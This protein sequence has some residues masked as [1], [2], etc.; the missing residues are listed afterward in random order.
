MLLFPRDADAGVVDRKV[1]A[2]V[3]RSTF[4]FHL[5]VDDDFALFGELDGVADQVDDHLPQPAGIA[6]Q[7]LRNLG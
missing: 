5:D 2:D 3:F 1:Q 6:N 4:G 7:N